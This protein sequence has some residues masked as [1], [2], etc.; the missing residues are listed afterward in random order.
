[1]SSP[2]HRLRSCQFCG[3]KRFPTSSDPT[4]SSRLHP[5]P[6]PPCA[7]QG[8]PLPRAALPAAGDLKVAGCQGRR[9]EDWGSERRR[10]EQ[11]KAGVGMGVVFHCACPR[12]G[13]A[14][15]ST[16]FSRFSRRSSTKPW[17]RSPP[18][19]ATAQPLERSPPL[20]TV[21]TAATAPRRQCNSCN[22]SPPTVKPVERSRVI[23]SETFRT[24]PSQ[25]F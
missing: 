9:R 11:G 14:A 7:P 22:S 15:K 17:E 10:G 8:A 6:C 12:F 5:S 13:R 25:T 4:S 21:A 16:V 1:M 2:S 24:I 23:P 20:A 18:T 3:E 19:A